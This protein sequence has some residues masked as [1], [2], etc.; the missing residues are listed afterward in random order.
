MRE[1]INNTTNEIIFFEA[2]MIKLTKRTSLNVSNIVWLMNITYYT[3]MNLCLDLFFQYI[4]Q[5]FAKK[6]N[7]VNNVHPI[8][9]EHTGNIVTHSVGDASK[10]AFRN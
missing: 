9:E 10:A 8:Q 1:G 7:N 3:S 4:F 5:G 2:Q 6:A